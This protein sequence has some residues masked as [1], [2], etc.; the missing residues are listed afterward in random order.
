M[1]RFFRSKAAVVGLVLLA[2]LVALGTVG[3]L[4]VPFPEAGA[5][6]RDIGYWQDN[7]AAAPPWWTQPGLGVGLPSVTQEGRTWTFRWTNPLEGPV[8]ISVPGNGAVPVRIQAEGSEGRMREIVRKVVDP[9]PGQPGR[10]SLDLAPS[11]ALRI[12][13]LGLEEDAAGPVVTVVGRASGW[14]GTDAAKRD[15][16]TGLVLGV[17][18]ALLLGLLVSFLTVSLGLAL[19]ILAACSGGWV[20]TLLNRIYEFFSL[21]PLLPLMIA[22]SAVYKPSLGTFLIL[23]LLFFWT[24]AFKPLYAQALQIRQE[25]YVEAGR[26]LG[27]GRWRLATRYV[28]PSLLPYGFALMALSVPGIL[29][30]EAS[31]GVVGLGDPSVV[32]WGQM[33]RDAFVQ[34]AVVNHLWWWVL[35]PGLMIGLT[36]LTFAL[37]GQGF[38]RLWKKTG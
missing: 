18:W 31:L 30:Y 3:P 5:R 37:L 13:L 4:L 19:G 11:A 20:D 15:V 35:P 34:G 9:S 1:S 28:L 32:T 22:L 26:S 25:G 16:F 23:A 2:L 21:L 12:T 6:W 8:V 17:R 29:L 10:I 14:L 27:A 7:P 38:D 33:L 24:K 36:G